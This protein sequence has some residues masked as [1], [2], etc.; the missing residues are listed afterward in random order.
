MHLYGCPYSYCLI[1]ILGETSP[2]VSIISLPSPSGS[3]S[4]FGLEYDSQSRTF[5]CTSTG[6]P[7]TNV[8]WRR[9]GFVI[10]L[11]AT[12]KQTKIVTNTTASTYQTVLTIDPSVSPSV[13]VGTY[14]CTVENNRGS[15]SSFYVIPGSGELTPYTQALFIKVTGYSPRMCRYHKFELNVQEFTL[16]S[17]ISQ[18]CFVTKIKA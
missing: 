18:L 15:S 6:G 12:H 17:H 4:M 2:N 16:N 14:N 10:T 9:D 11:N 7:A 3:P 13:I 1:C 5:T 8:T